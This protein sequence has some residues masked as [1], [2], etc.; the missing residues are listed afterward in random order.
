MTSPPLERYAFPLLP[1]DASGRIVELDAAWR[2]EGPV[3][4][5][6]V[7]CGRPPRRSIAPLKAA[8]ANA[9]QRD[10]FIRRCKRE[11]GSEV[12]AVQ[13]LPPPPGSSAPVVGAVR[14][15]LLSGALVVLSSNE[16]PSVLDT[17]ARAAGAGATPS[18]FHVPGDGSAVARIVTATGP[19]ILRMARRD[20]ASDP[21]RIGDALESLERAGL[22]AVPRVAGRG[23]VQDISWITET[24]LPGAGPRTISPRLGA[25][26]VDFSSRLP[27]AEGP[28]R[29]PDEDLD[30]VA[31]HFPDHVD[32]VETIRS[33]IAEGLGALPG[34]ARHGDFWA[35]NILTRGDELTGVVDWAAW[36]PSAAPGTDLVHLFVAGRKKKARG[37]LGD[38]WARRP[39]EQAEFLDWTGPYWRSLGV[40]PKAEVL[41]AVALAWWAS[42][43]AQSVTRHPGRARQRS[44]VAGNVERVV[45]AW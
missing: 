42:W 44:W 19:R 27:R 35:G 18:A 17:V 9:V 45:N 31:R 26:L 20:E 5:E 7:V 21:A 37:E 12:R 43:V 15:R 41:E 10:R 6:T 1:A 32:A 11:R 24:V 8:V 22:D 28:A 36:H 38:A 3:E 4:K 33:R 23:T 29:A 25:Q 14:E 34:V 40:D 2:L 30:V 16:V 39:W 13:L